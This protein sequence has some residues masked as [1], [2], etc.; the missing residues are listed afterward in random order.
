M[1]FGPR[2]ANSVI[3]S[4]SPCNFIRE[5]AAMDEI[6][7]LDVDDHLGFRSSWGPFVIGIT[8]SDGQS[9]SWKHPVTLPRGFCVEILSPVIKSNSPRVWDIHW[10]T[11]LEAD[12]AEVDTVKNPHSCTNWT[13]KM[14][15]RL[16]CKNYAFSHVDRSGIQSVCEGRN[17]V[18]CIMI[19]KSTQ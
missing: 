1:L 7:I 5:V 18:V 12:G 17:R 3:M 16:E 13:H 9:W 4:L 2:K 6:P 10:L 11:R 8:I 19:I 15:H 14:S